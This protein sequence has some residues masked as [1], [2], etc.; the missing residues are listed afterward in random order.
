V[1]FKVYLAV[2]K[3]S[4]SNWQWKKLISYLLQGVLVVAPVT[5]TF[6]VIYS[7]FSTIDNL[8][9][10]FTFEDNY[11]NTK[12]QNYGVGFLAITVALIFIGFLSRNFIAAKVF[13]LFE[14]LLERMPGVK[15]IYTSVKD[16]F[17]AFTGN[18][19]KFTK[20]VLVN[21]LGEDVWQIGFI[22]D[23]TASE[24]G[25]AQHVSVY[26]PQSYAFA[27]HLFIVPNNKVKA[28]ETL[29]SADAMK[30]AIS[31]GVVEFDHKATAKATEKK[32]N[33]DLE[34]KK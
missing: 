1:L 10:I 6:W 2:Q 7:I 22:T 27:G 25:M 30:Y 12:I 32:P 18:K 31:G 15:F 20:P 24:F 34:N 17:E 28:I 26:V 23:D 8:L 4:M 21:I 3:R 13:S 19:K 16:F 11:G 5:V 29:N 9:P 33:E 14:S